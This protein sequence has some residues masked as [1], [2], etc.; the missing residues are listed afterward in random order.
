M[1]KSVK[2]VGGKTVVPL[3][4]TPSGTSQPGEFDQATGSLLPC[5]RFQTDEQRLGIK[6]S[7]RRLSGPGMGGPGEPL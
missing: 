5:Q 1:S 4:R 6:P 7:N 2:I 3:P